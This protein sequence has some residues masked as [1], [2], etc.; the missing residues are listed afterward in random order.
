MGVD[1]KYD[2]KAN[3][4]QTITDDATWQEISDCTITL[5]NSGG[6][7]IIKCR[8]NCSMNTNN[9]PVMRVRLMDDGV[10]EVVWRPAAHYENPV[11]FSWDFDWEMDDDGSVLTIEV[12]SPTISSGNVT[13]R[14]GTSIMA[15]ELS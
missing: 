10:E 1:Y 11:Y 15:M 9:L 3:G 8:V 4:N 5:A 12:Y 6:K 7:A 14:N 13:V 2:K